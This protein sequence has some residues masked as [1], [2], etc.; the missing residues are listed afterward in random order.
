[1]RSASVEDLGEGFG[2]P[3]AAITLGKKKEDRVEGRKAGRRQNKTTPSPLAQGLSPPL[4][5]L[6][7]FARRPVLI[8]WKWLLRI[9]VSLTVFRAE[10]QC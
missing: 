1:M 6:L 3:E 4:V 10:N 2:G 9:F 7:R 8:T 5:Q